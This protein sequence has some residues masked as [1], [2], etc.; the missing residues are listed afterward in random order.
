MLFDG[1]DLSIEDIAGLARRQTQAE[2]SSQAEFIAR[3]D[4]GA[5]FV[6]RLLK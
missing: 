5:A 2:L 4:K 1:A 6:D 3:I